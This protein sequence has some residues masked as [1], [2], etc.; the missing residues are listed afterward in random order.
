MVCPVQA[1]GTYQLYAV[2]FNKFPRPIPTPISNL[3]PAQETCEQCHWPKQ[4][5]SEKEIKNTYFMSDEKNTRW[6][7]N[8]LIKIGGGTSKPDPHPA[9][10]GT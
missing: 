8:L 5:F 10:T 3:R 6:S 2:T 1:F 4:F 9:S 7:L